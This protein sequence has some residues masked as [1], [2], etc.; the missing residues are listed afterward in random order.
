[1]NK[2]CSR[3]TQKD[4]FNSI[5]K[6]FS[7]KTMLRRVV[8]MVCLMV[9]MVA[10]V[11]AQNSFAY[12]AVIRNAKGEL[13]SNQ[14]ISM[15][16]SLIYEGQVVYSETHTPKTNQYG[17]VQVNVGEGT[18]VSGKFADVPWSS[19]KVMMKIEADPSGGNSYIDFGTIQLQPAPYAMYAP[20]AGAVSTIQAGEPKSD[21]DALFEVKDK[22]G[23]VVFAVYR[24][25]VRVFV[26]DAD[27]TSNKAMRTG[28]AVAGRRAAKEGGEADIFSVTADGTQVFVSDEDTAGGK[29]MRTGFAVAGRRAA[30]EMNADLFTVSSTGT[31]IYINNDEDGDKAMRTGFAVAGRR[32]AKDD[33]KYLEINADGTRVYIDDDTIDNSGK[34]MRTGFAVAGRRAA[35]GDADNKYME[36]AADGTQIY[37]DDDGKAMRTGFAVAGRRAA[38]G[39]SIKLFEVN[40]FGTKIYIDETAGK[41]MRTGFAVAGRRAA[42]DGNSNKYMV[43][44]ADGTRIYVD[45]EEAKAM[46]TGFAVAGRRAA[47]DAE[48]NTILKVDNVEGTRAYIDDNEGKAM[49]TGFAVSGRRAAKDGDPDLM[50][51]TSE[52]STLTA[53]NFAMQDKQTSNN[54]MSITPVNTKINTDSFV[55][56]NT[57]SDEHLFATNTEGAE[58]NANIVLLG[59][60]AQSVES[61]LI[62]DTLL[63]IN[64]IVA[65]QC[66]Q[67]AA[68][69]GEAG[70]YQLLKIYGS[71]LFAPALS[72]DADGN[73]YILF[74]ANGNISTMDKA[75]VAVVM[76]N[77]AT[78]DAQVLVWPIKQT[79]ST[80]ISFGLMAA[81]SADQYVKVVAAVN[82]QEGV[83]RKVEIQAENGSVEITGHQVYGELVTLNAKPDLGYDFENW[84]DGYS[85]ESR[86]LKFTGTTDLTA[87]FK[88][89]TYN[90]IVE[91]IDE[92]GNQVE[93]EVTVTGDLTYNSKVTLEAPQLSGYEFVKWKIGDVEENENPLEVTITSDTSFMA[94]YKIRENLIT[95]NAQQCKAVAGTLTK[96]GS[97]TTETITFTA[98]NGI[99]TC[100]CPQG[101]KLT[102]HAEPEA[103]YEFSGWQVEG[104][105]IVGDYTIES[106]TDE[107]SL[108]A[109]FEPIKYSINYNY[110]GGSLAQGASNPAYYYI[111]DNDITL[112]EPIKEGY[113]FK[114]WKEKVDDGEET[115]NESVVIETGSIGNR[116]YTA[117]WNPQQL[118]ITTNVN[119]TDFG[120][121]TEGG[122]FDYGSSVTI[123]A[124]AKPGYKFAGWYGA[125]NKPVEADNNISMSGENGCQLDI[126]AVKGSATYIAVFE[127]DTKKLT[128]KISQAGAGEVKVY[129]SD[130]KEIT[131]NEPDGASVSLDGSTQQPTEWM[132]E[133]ITG[134]TAT[135][136][137]TANDGYSFASW[138]DGV[139]DAERTITMSEDQELMATFKNVLYVSSKGKSNN[140]GT[141]S[142]EP[143][144]TIA[145]ALS[146]IP[147]ESNPDNWK[148]WEIR[149]SGT[150]TGSQTIQGTVNNGG[151]VSVV[152]P[153][154]AKSITLTGYNGLG[155]DGQPQDVIDGGW[156][157]T[158][159]NSG[160]ETWVN[161]NQSANPSPAL[162]IRNVS[163]PVIIKNLAITGGYAENGAGINI[164]EGINVIIGTGTFI[165]DNKATDKGGGVMIA[166]GSTLEMPGGEI[167]GNN[168]RLGGGVYVAFEARFE[169]TGG[170]ISSN[171]SEDQGGGICN[172]GKIF[173]SG[174]AVIGDATKTKQA[175]ANNYSNKALYGGGIYN[176]G[177]LYLGYKDEETRATLDGGAFYNYAESGGGINVT[178]GTLY[179]NSGTVAYN[180][181]NTGG[182][183]YIHYY[184][185]FHISGGQIVRNKATDSGGGIYSDDDYE[186]PE[187]HVFSGD[188]SIA[189]NTAKNNG[190]GICLN[191][192]KISLSGNVKIASDNDVYL[193]SSCIYIAGD[194]AE[195]AVATIT[196]ANYSQETPVLKK[197]AE[198]ANES[199]ISNNYSKFA[200][201]PYEY[202]DGTISYYKVKSDGTLSSFNAVEFGYYKYN[203][204]TEENEFIQVAFIEQSA[205]LHVDNGEDEYYKFPAAPTENLPEELTGN[206]FVGWFVYGVAPYDVRE[207]G[208]IKWGD[209]SM[210]F[211]SSTRVVA[212]RK[213]VVDVGAGTSIADAFSRF[214]YY[215]DYTINLTEDLS[216][217]QRI[218]GEYNHYYYEIKQHSITIEGNNHTIDASNPQEPAAALS[219]NGNIPLTIKNLTVT[220]GNDGGI[221]IYQSQECSVM[222]DGVTAT[223]NESAYGGGI[224]VEQ[225]SGSVTLKNVTVTDNEA[226]QEGGGVSFSGGKIYMIGGFISGNATGGK[227]GGVYLTHGAKLFMSGSAVVGSIDA[228]TVADADNYSNK[229]SSGGGV[230]LDSNS[231]GLGGRCEL[232][233]GYTDETTI[234]ADFSGGIVYNYA[235]SC[236]GVYNNYGNVKMSGGKI[237]Y[238]CGASSSGGGA[239]TNQSFTMTGGTIIG[240]KAGWSGNGV[241]ASGSFSLSGTAKVDLGNDVS[242]GSS[243]KITIDGELEG[244]EPVAVITPWVYFENNDNLFKGDYAANYYSRFNVTPD[245]GALWKIDEYGKLKHTSP[246]G[247]IYKEFS[248]SETRKVYFSRGNLQYANGKWKMAV[249]QNGVASVVGNEDIENTT[250]AID[251]FGWGTGESAKRCTTEVGEYS[252]YKEWGANS[253][254]KYGTGDII[255]EGSWRTL[256]GSEWS[257]LLERNGKSGFANI[258]GGTGQIE[259]GLVLLPDEWNLPDGL[260]FTPGETN[261]Y[262]HSEWVLMENAGAVFLPMAGVRNG[263]GSGSVSN[264]GSQGNYWSAQASQDET[265]MALQFT[266]EGASVTGTTQ[267]FMGF[268]VRLVQDLPDANAFSVPSTDYQTI[269]D[270]I[271]AIN[272]QSLDYTINV[273]GDLSGNEITLSSELDGKAASITFV[274]Q[275]S[276]AKFGTVNIPTSVPV[277]FKNIAIANVSGYGTDNNQ[278]VTFD[279]GAIVSGTVSFSERTITMLGGSKVGSISDGGSTDVKMHGGEVTGID[280]DGD[281]VFDEYVVMASGTFTMS[282]S[283]KPHQVKTS[284]KIMIDGQFTYNDNDDYVTFIDY[285]DYES[286]LGQPVLERADGFEGDL[287]FNR[288]ALANEGY[289]ISDK[290]AVQKKENGTSDATTIWVGGDNASDDYENSSQDA[291]FA[292]IDRASSFINEGNPNGS[293]ETNYVIKVTGTIEGEGYLDIYEGKAASVRIEGTSSLVNGVPQDVI[294]NGLT[295]RT[296]EEVVVTLKNIKITST[297][298]GLYVG[299]GEDWE[300]SH[301]ILDSGVLIE[302]C[303]VDGE[304]TNGVVV[305]ANSTIEIQEGCVISNNRGVRGSGVQVYNG[306]QL[307]LDAG[308]VVDAS[309]DVWLQTG[310]TVTVAGLNEGTEKIATITPEDYNY[311]GALIVVND[312][313]SL[314]DACAR[315]DVTRKDN[316]CYGIDS[317]G[318]LEKIS[319]GGTSNNGGGMPEG[320]TKVD[321]GT[322]DISYNVGWN[323]NDYEGDNMIIPSLLVCNHLVSQYEYEQLMTYYGAV[324]SEHSDLQPSETSE[325]AKKNTPAYYVS[326]IDAIIYCNLLSMA[327]H[328]DP[329]YS[330]NDVTDPAD[331]IW[332]NWSAAQVEGKYYSNDIS[333]GTGW[334]SDGGNFKFNFSANGYRLLTS[335]EFNYLLQHEHDLIANG[336]Y[337]EWCNTYK[338]DS[339]CKRVWY[340]GENDEVADGEDAKYNYTRESNMGFRIVRNAPAQQP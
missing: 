182:G 142:S 14:E 180:S 222:L 119:S 46:R 89:H 257:Y 17:N 124:T 241:F 73:S 152:E 13:V 49:R 116:Q 230:Y 85:T 174:S 123:T 283:A 51:I 88:I 72:V 240:N 39:E 69:L 316:N 193:G 331:E 262:T 129:G 52:Q 15:Q 16:F 317:N 175:D 259:S 214:D 172:Y 126:E 121:V 95:V 3:E 133:I 136:K 37:V 188:V 92:A 32:A 161:G 189:S 210:D 280:N 158:I 140:S 61:K 202:Y 4:T 211:S 203:D 107:I 199:V 251:L 314:S 30:K 90:I 192:A 21:S 76:T 305:N 149:I 151:D 208:K 309:N 94:I 5:F 269:D 99:F 286:M 264:V 93:G 335:A 238:N 146:R 215:C 288:F 206:D 122:T 318:I 258:D 132:A 271:N 159:D 220:G 77:A 44:D 55:L 298:I 292:T 196:P 312:G 108:E 48:S 60:Q 296:S 144:P 26:D 340:D 308:A 147:Q 303:G 244:S 323:D 125:D 43:I 261:E 137:V 103:G 201:T 114:G 71:D 54:I 63:S 339:E 249:S 67:T 237:A 197:P 272:G 138:S 41:A 321:G 150:L 242:L 225:G 96:S 50:R 186:T 277:I 83:E 290:G 66:A 86:T 106:V 332:G 62:A 190:N 232:Y 252:V 243:T 267:R 273:T 7:M 293:S 168:S 145:E 160:Y 97:E 139:A 100:T 274:G 236:G 315:F 56:T 80:N 200:V 212:V 184:A 81:N 233:I 79:N 338:Y 187:N 239:Y 127:P 91:A 300:S 68:V 284:N 78:P 183:L 118:K 42:K 265:A 209:Q 165:T 113:D 155:N 111:T 198:G 204:K 57:E 120:S 254:I 330:I 248:V 64:E 324:H 224:Y 82:A 143:V 162:T 328:K 336:N 247:V 135:V 18:A 327:E 74:D 304:Y 310:A 266:A 131:L 101:A 253:P 268:S 281:N 53:T 255:V 223:G 1:M 141:L 8:A 154:P 20:A 287:P 217:P 105:T 285:Y 128:V 112:A 110:D 207:D 163:A 59:E 246:Y 279:N 36:I 170:K 102:I 134:S 176:Q 235:N 6:F 311:D 130:G 260:S 307:I 213:K 216:K 34:A 167:S 12:Q 22:D 334:D 75:V 302:G 10:T 164:D 294:N 84:S 31:Q 166:K 24:D 109:I 229:A 153:I 148:D 65:L 256:T 29:A 195:D 329:V 70:G 179:M 226:G 58:V 38:K 19:M 227:G 177:I 319:C 320:F 295:V 297:N 275:G 263:S 23:N 169:M 270:A 228:T 299:N 157:K 171:V 104:N 173:M 337:N 191:G 25:G 326:W 87:N 2:Y 115:E 194:L 98:S 245:V 276:N 219:F 9:A 205:D 231:D 28:F 291:P 221:S 47:K 218:E 45:Y 313:V 282:G 181:S 117:I 234:D 301:V 11:E 306:C 27:S 289:E 250:Y 33:D 333:D 40:S 185:P 156:R 278:D 35:K 178:S 322:I 325:E